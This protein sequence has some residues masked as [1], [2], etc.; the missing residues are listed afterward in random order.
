MSQSLKQLH[1]RWRPAT[2][3]EVIGQP[4][5]IKRIQRIQDT[6]GLGGRAYYIA[7]PSGGGKTTIARLIAADIADPMNIDE[8]D[9]TGLSAAALQDIERSMRCYGMGA[10]TGRAVILNECH[11]LNKAAVR[12]LLTTFERIPGH[13]VWILTTTIEGEECLFDGIDAN[14][15]LSRC[16]DLPMARRG[17]CESMAKRALEIA[18]AENLDG[19]PLPAYIELVKQCRNNFRKVLTEIECGRMLED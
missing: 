18:R 7:G 1:E 17:V 12:Q 13:T 3:A 5:V 11:G 2:F 6:S 19:R 9:A 8:I 10:K 15:L 4:K 14:P 16:I